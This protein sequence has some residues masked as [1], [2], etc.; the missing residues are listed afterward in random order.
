MLFHL[1][2]VIVGFWFY[3]D[4]CES[5][6]ECYDWETVDS[7]GALDKRYVV[8]CTG[9]IPEFLPG[10]TTDLI[11]SRCFLGTLS[12]ASFPFSPKFLSVSLTDCRVKYFL[13]D[14]FQGNS[15]VAIKNIT[16]SRNIL[17]S[18]IAEGTFSHLIDIENI[19]MYGNFLR[20]VQRKAFRDLPQV[21]AIN[22][23]HNIIEEVQQGAFDNLPLLEVLD[24]SN[25]SLKSIPGEDIAGLPSLKLLNLNNNH[26]NCSCQM[27]WI[28]SFSSILVDSGKTICWYPATLN[29]TKLQQLTTYDFQHCGSSYNLKNINLIGVSILLLIYAFFLAHQSGESQT[30][31]SPKDALADNVFKGKFGG[32]IVA[33]KR[34]PPLCYIKELDILLHLSKNGPIHRNVIQYRAVKRGAKY[35]DIY[36]ELCEGNLETAISDQRF[37]PFL[38]PECCLF[39]LASGVDFLNHEGIVHRDI[40]PRNILWNFSGEEVRFIIS[41]FDVSRFIKD[42]SSHKARCGTE[43]WSAP[44]LWSNT[45][46]ERDTA[47]DIFSLGCI[48]YY[49]LTRGRH[50]FGPIADKI[51]RQQNI[52]SG[53]FLLKSLDD[54]HDEFVVALAKDLIGEMIASNSSSRPS[55][56]KILKHPLFWTGEDEIYQFYNNISKCMKGKQGPCV[57]QLKKILKDDATMVFENNGLPDGEAIENNWINGLPDGEAKT[58]LNKKYGKHSGEIYFLI[59]AIRDKVQH[60]KQLPPEA[61]DDFERYGGVI[62]YFHRCYPNLLAYAYRRWEKSGVSTGQE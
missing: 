31:F 6:C 19:S 32:E 62:K 18:I 20:K 29:G 52:N 9:G 50:P 5:E 59:T 8:N 15:F 41:D 10:N 25:N 45:E 56:E 40:K 53:K 21:H 24:L 54:L 39:Q 12:T 16:I 4:P 51:V 38:T 57:K 13:F 60:F 7:A 14:T 28:L 46:G 26:W 49:V 17:D 3:N 2:F 34:H 61:R 37:F 23:S 43:G 42:K 48:F 58:T 44:E 11:V 30:E 1:C 47:V 36:L 55:A 33:V 22:L 35:T 27:S